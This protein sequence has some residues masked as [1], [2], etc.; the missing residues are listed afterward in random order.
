MF[1]GFYSPDQFI[2][3]DDF[4]EEEWPWPYRPEDRPCRLDVIDVKGRVINA[5]IAFTIL[6]IY[7]V[8]T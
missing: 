2:G 5:I 1:G 7:M 3:K 8:V 6:A 4:T